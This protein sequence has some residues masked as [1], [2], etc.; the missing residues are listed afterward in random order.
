MED[1]QIFK[2]LLTAEEQQR[3]ETI[4]K[5]IL[6]KLEASADV[7]KAVMKH[8]RAMSCIAASFSSDGQKAMRA[9][10]D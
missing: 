5:E 1:L 7:S 10:M 8:A 2:W 6:K 9:T 3:V 4:T